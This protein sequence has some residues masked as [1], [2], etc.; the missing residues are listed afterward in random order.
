MS[1]FQRFI[2]VFAYLLAISLIL[3]ICTGIFQLV[4]TFIPTT[5]KVVV[6]DYYKEFKNINSLELNINAADLKIETGEKL[7]IKASNLVSKIK[8]KEEDG[9][10]KV[11]QNKIRVNN[12]SAGFII[13]TIPSELDNFLLN[14]GAG[15]IDIDELN[16]QKVDLSLGFGNV[17]ISNVKFGS[18]KISGGA[19]NIVIEK[20]LLNNLDLNSGAGNVRINAEIKGKSSID[21][22]LGE[23][24]LLLG[25]KEDS[26]TINAE[27]GL[28]NLTINNKNYGDKVTYGEGKN[29]INIE[30]GVGNIYIRFQK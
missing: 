26:Y 20:S 14:G 24:N 30:G 22:G 27:K 11:K 18:T 6:E 9:I 21:C 4:N 13:I 28:G 8:V 15:K 16:A 10:L 3:S 12:Q 25:G 2:K 19:G 1:T 29:I 7:T 5:E 17:T 23:I